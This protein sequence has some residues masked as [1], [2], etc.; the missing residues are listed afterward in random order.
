MRNSAHVNQAMRWVRAHYKSRSA[1]PFGIRIAT[2]GHWA[3]LSRPFL[4]NSMADQG[5]RGGAGGCADSCSAD[6]A[7]GGTADD[8][9]CGRPIAGAG[10]GGSLT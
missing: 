2:G 4:G 6:M 3:I 8:C 5:T 9:A 10:T 7:R 1:A